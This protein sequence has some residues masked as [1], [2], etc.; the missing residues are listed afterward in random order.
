MKPHYFLAI[1][2]AETCQSASEIRERVDKALKCM[3]REPLC[4]FSS[5]CV[6]TRMDIAKELKTMN[7]LPHV[8]G[9]AILNDDSVVAKRDAFFAAM[10]AIGHKVQ[11]KVPAMAPSQQDCQSV[12]TEE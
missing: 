10:R 7:L 8:R 11:L 12:H 4:Q 9:N 5:T 3:Y 1:A 2:L 6:L